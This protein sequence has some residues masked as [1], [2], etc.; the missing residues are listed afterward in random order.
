MKL[1]NNETIKE[2][3]QASP[4]ELLIELQEILSGIRAA[5]IRLA[6]MQQRYIVFITEKIMQH[7]ELKN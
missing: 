7:E 1:P 4:A 6:E 3:L 2:V 5:E